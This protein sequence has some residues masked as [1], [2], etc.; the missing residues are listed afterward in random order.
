[1][2]E[3]DAYLVDCLPGTPPDSALQH[4]LLSDLSAAVA[5][6]GLVAAF[7][8]RRR[9]AEMALAEIRDVSAATGP[10]TLFE[11]QVPAEVALVARMPAQVRPAAARLMARPT[12]GLAA[13]SAA[14]TR[15]A[16]HLCLEGTGDRGFGSVSGLNPLVLL[17]SA[18]I[19]GWP[20][21]RALDLVHMPFTS[22]E[23]PPSTDPGFYRPLLGLQVP[24]GT[25]FAAGFAHEAQAVD[26]QRTILG[27]IE[28]QI[29]SEVVVAPGCGRSRRPPEARR[30]MTDRLAEL[31][32]S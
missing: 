17:S 21:G 5:T 6:H 20:A 4:G 24:A 19:A 18:I 14:G 10:D 3:R 28:E 7:R 31:C 30:A 8:G 25:R 32:T 23:R 22:G 13:G 1:M 29:G 27:I 26:V 15:F 11:V 16:V 2:A 9:F 12:T